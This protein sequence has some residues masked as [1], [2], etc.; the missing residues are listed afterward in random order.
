MA[1]ALGSGVLDSPAWQGFLPA[2]AEQLTGQKLLL[3][4]VAT[5]WCGEAPALEDAIHHLDKVI[6]KGTYPNQRFTPVF[7]DQ[8]DA[9]GREQLVARLRSRPYAYVAQERV[10]FSQA[11][12]WRS[13]SDMTLDARP[14]GIR[15]YVIATPSGYAVMPGGMARIA[16]ETALDIISTQ[17]GGGS[18]D[19]WVLSESSQ[20]QAAQSEDTPDRLME[21]H[22]E[23]PSDLVENLHWLGRYSERCVDNTRLLRAT[24]SARADSAVWSRALSTC[25]DLGLLAE[26]G[27]PLDSL[28]DPALPTGLAADLGR[29]AWA[30]TRSRSRLSAEHWRSLTLLQKQVEKSAGDLLEPRAMLDHLLVGL[31]AMAGFSLDDMTQDDGWRFLMLGRLLERM[32]FQ[33]NLFASMLYKGR[34][35]IVGELEW[36]LDVSGSVITYRTRY[37][38]TPRMRPVLELLVVDTANPRALAFHW[39]GVNTL[40]GEIS[41]TFD[42]QLDDS[43]NV[44]MQALTDA[45][46]GGNLDGRDARARLARQRVSEAAAEF[47]LAVDKLSDRLATRYFSHTSDAQ[48]MVAA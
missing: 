7:G 21:R 4:S 48:K 2:I 22:A 3:P 27:E 47:S 29:L 5:W 11:P 20:V 9:V 24:F 41:R 30:A 14:F 1:N 39:Q 40:L 8:L 12:V 38:S 16:S 36:L 19:L 33:S 34:L 31:A 44:P 42:M 35:P 26:E 10:R 25:R 43:M 13:S 23:L 32:R 6:I 17:R 18:K 46:Y 15:A 45:V 28:L 37:L